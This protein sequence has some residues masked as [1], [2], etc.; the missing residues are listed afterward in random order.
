MTRM[1]GRARTAA[2][3]VAAAITMSVTVLG[4]GITQADAVERVRLAEDVTVA[5]GITYQAFSVTASHGKVTG[6][7]ITA[8]LS[9]SRVSVGM[10]TPGKVSARTKLSQL[11]SA[12]GAV[13]GVNADFFNIDETQH[14]GVPATNSAVGPAIDNGVALKSAV[15]NG[16]RFGPGLSPGTS[17][18]DVIGVDYKNVA[19]L[20]SLTLDGSI[21]GHRDKE[22]GLDGF[23]QYAIPVGGIGAFT[24]QWGDISRMRATCG[25]DTVRAAAC[26]TDVYEVTVRNNRVVSGSSTIGAGAIDA[27]SVVLVGREAGAAELRS[28]EIGEHIRVSEDLDSAGGNRLK[29]AVGGNPVLRDGEPIAGLDNKAVATRTG[30]AFGDGGRLLYLLVLDGTAE[31][32]AGLTV[33]E[34]AGVF[35]SVGADNGVNLDGGGS[36]TLVTR[37][38]VTGLPVV[39]NHPTGGAERPVPEGI[40]L[41]SRA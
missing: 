33:A 21:K 20:D 7:V 15:P 22:L 39:R 30:A 29:F 26:S 28:L 23:N 4:A 36:S 11:V 6:H 24:S 35:Q 1:T 31:S 37:D 40:G 9:D 13:A 27:D 16:Q 19:H 41:F 12:Q 5:P 2:A 17:T 8:D 14:P 3:S 38:A 32:G 34:L 18:R 25:T 10:L